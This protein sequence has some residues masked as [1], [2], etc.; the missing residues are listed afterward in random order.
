M[1]NTIKDCPG[2][3]GNGVC[4]VCAGAGCIP[5]H[6]TGRCWQCQDAGDAGSLL[7][8]LGY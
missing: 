1:D 6:G 2:C 5:C 3:F 7:A 8:F 4:V